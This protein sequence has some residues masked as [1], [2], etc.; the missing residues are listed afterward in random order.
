MKKGI[1][2]LFW[3]CLYFLPALFP[4][5]YLLLNGGVDHAV[6]MNQRRWGLLENSLWIAGSCAIVC[7]VI[8]MFAAMR[9]YG[10]FRTKPVLRWF[11]LILAPVPS[12][13]YALSYMNLI[14]LL[15]NFVPGLLRFRM[16]GM[17]PCILVESLAFL[18]YAC[19]AA[20]IGL[21]QMDRKE[22]K[23][24]LLLQDADSVFWK[25]VLP[26]Q[27]PYL[28]A[29]GAV[30]FV[31]SVTDYSIPSLFQVNVYAME[32]FSDYSAVGQSVHSLSLALPLIAVASGVIVLAL[33]PMRNVSR[34]DTTGES[35]APQYSK[36]LRRTGSCAVAVLVVQIVFPFLSFLPYLGRLTEA[37]V[38]AGRELMNSFIT[39]IWAVILLTIPAAGMALLLGEKMTEKFFLWIAAAF[40]LAVPGMLSGI[41]VLKVFSDT[42]LHV[43]RS[44]NFMPAVGMAVRYLPLA[45]M[46][47][48]GCYLRMDR[49]RIRAA[50]LLQRYPGEAFWRVQLHLMRPGLVI[51]GI[52]VFL[53]TLGDVGT[54][55]ILMPAGREPL[56][57]KIYNYLHYGSTETVA[58][59]CM[60]QVAVCVLLMGAL[61]IVIRR[62]ILWNRQKG[63]A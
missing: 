2:K 34:L 18:P 43:F 39:G 52:V 61:Y 49:D 16:A 44:G 14:R 6:K 7:V 10:A 50:R 3:C 54:A 11:F 27:S 9:L 5:V 38:P 33:V 32:I 19:A 12:Y 17:V 24:A 59:F 63:E 20:L 41:G 25:I 46:I 28:I 51:S 31:L 37:V 45:M 57:V 48:Y 4:T 22:W 58:V 1:C 29:M 60:L 53:L 35:M 55:L 13:I 21:E 62:K 56:S 47:Q 40:P 36:G 26:R 8:A 30:I 15:G 23:A 42:P